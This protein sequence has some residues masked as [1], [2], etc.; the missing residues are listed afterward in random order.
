MT[1]GEDLQREAYFGTG[2]LSVEADSLSRFSN[3]L[4]ILGCDEKYRADV[5]LEAI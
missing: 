1:V 5:P 4:K 3:D 2:T